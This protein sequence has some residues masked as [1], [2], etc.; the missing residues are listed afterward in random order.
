MSHEESKISPVLMTRDGFRNAV[1]NRDNNQ[2]VICKDSTDPVAHHIMER[3]L[4]SDG[5]Y[6]SENGATLCEEHHILAEQTILSCE[7]IREAAGITIILLPPRLY[8]DTRYEKWSNII[9]PDG[10]RLKGE[11]FFD[12]SVQKI[13]K[14]GGVLDQFCKYVKYPRTWHLPWSHKVHRNDMQL[15]SAKHFEGKEVVVTIKMDGENT[16][17]YND[18][19]HARSVDSA[20]HPTRGWAKRI[21][22]E[23]GWSIPED[24]RV[25]AENMYAKHTVIYENL[26][27]Y[28]LVFSIWNEKNECLSWDDTLEWAELLD[29]A[30]TPVLYT[31]EW[32]EKKIHSLCPEE[33]NGDKVEGYV[34]RLV[35]SFTYGD[36]RK[37]VA[38]YVKPEFADQL[39]V[40]SSHWKYKAIIPNKLKA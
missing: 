36:F 3:R 23:K 14:S 40:G 37:S 20:N 18:Y 31:G 34:V 1:F 5:G 32:D 8:Q 29:F 30:M 11:L 19:L 15:D 28:L 17:M 6:Y 9:L 25:C 13:L 12:S 21:H 10:R 39:R 4:W 35:E 22:A 27:A 33:Y 38:K 7:E 26:D 24:W 16:T 2:C